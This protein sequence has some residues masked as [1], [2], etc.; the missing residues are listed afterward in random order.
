MA[1]PLCKLEGTW[2]EITARVPDFATRKL[3]VIVYDAEE[4]RQAASSTLSTGER[5]EGRQ[6]TLTEA[7]REIE[8]R[9]RF[10]NPKPDSHD[11]LREARSG[12]MFGLNADE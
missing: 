3:E 11:Y 12:A 5:I 4:T 8:E 1:I 2:Q 7:L 10:M 9:S 6:K